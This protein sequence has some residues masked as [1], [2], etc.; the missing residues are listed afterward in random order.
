MVFLWCV[1]PCVFFLGNIINF[2]QTLTNIQ[3]GHVSNSPSKPNMNNINHQDQSQQPHQ[4]PRSITTTTTTTTTK[5][6]TWIRI[7][8]I[9]NIWHY[10]H[11]T[12]MDYWSLFC[13]CNQARTGLCFVERSISTRHCVPTPI[14]SCGK[15]TF[16]P[17]ECKRVRD[18]HTINMR[19]SITEVPLWLSLRVCNLIFSVWCVDMKASD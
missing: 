8:T 19:W 12:S 6:G 7:K 15:N 17:F 18:H 11:Y 9:E 13:K 16:S 14:A 3:N 1:R 4:P 5:A 10:K 2:W